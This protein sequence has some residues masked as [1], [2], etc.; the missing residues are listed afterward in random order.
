M[1]P[2]YTFFAV[3]KGH[4]TLIQFSNGINMM[5]DCRSSPSRPSPLQYL[6]TKVRTLDFVVITHPHQDHLTGLKDVCEHY[7][8][9]YL[10]HNGRY[11]LPDPVYEDW[12]YYER[13]R[14]GKISYCSPEHVRSGKTATIGDSRIYLAS[15]LIP[16]LEGTSEDENNNGIILSILTGNAKVVLTGDTEQD[17][18]SAVD[19]RTLAKPSVFLASHHGR[20]SGFS[21]EAMAAIKPQHIVI[22]DGEPADTDATEKYRKIAPVTTTREKSIVLRPTPGV[23]RVAR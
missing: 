22:S 2:T 5:V 9:R 10:W 8:P 6:Q 19:L 1:I 18:W 23:A 4:M 3:D 16:N 15:P 14:T 7:R 12:S 21:A 20:D 17:Q 11:F 13:L